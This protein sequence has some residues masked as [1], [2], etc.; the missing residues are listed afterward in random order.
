MSCS[1]TFEKYR[2]PLWPWET[3]LSWVIGSMA[4]RK[5]RCEEGV[6][7]MTT[8][9]TITIVLTFEHFRRQAGGQE[10]AITWFSPLKSA[11]C[12]LCTRNQRAKHLL[13]CEAWGRAG[14]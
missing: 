6:R 9:I 11:A 5:Q 4:V 12:V 7:A 14:F 13:D 8:V 3:R 10:L 2:S 1:I